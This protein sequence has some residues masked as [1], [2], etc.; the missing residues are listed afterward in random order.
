LTFRPAHD[1]LTLTQPPTGQIATAA[2]GGPLT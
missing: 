1:W 2:W